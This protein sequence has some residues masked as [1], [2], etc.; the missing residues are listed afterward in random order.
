VLTFLV[1]LAAIAAL[2]AQNILANR[3]LRSAVTLERARQDLLLNRLAS[4]TLG[5]YTAASQ[6]QG[7]HPVPEPESIDQ[8]MRYLYDETGLVRIQ[9]PP[10]VD[11]DAY[12]EAGSM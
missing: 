8:A 6:A 11:D 1:A 2:V 3:T 10:N 7:Y 4:R 9:A 5:E 12:V